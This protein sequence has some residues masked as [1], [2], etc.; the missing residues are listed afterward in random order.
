M[1]SQTA[2]ITCPTPG[3]T[4]STTDPA[5]H[6][7]THCT[8]FLRFGECDYWPA[9][10][11]S[12]ERPEGSVR[13]C[14]SRL[15]S[16]PKKIASSICGSEEGEKEEADAGDG[17]V[18]VLAREMLDSLETASIGGLGDMDID[19]TFVEGISG[20]AKVAEGQLISLV[21]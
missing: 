3:R 9:C 16:S 21:D 1:S 12:H 6:I 4:I 10:K 2:T 8:F 11:F 17:G 5:K 7:K 13:W 14:G 20:I 15:P 18:T 19:M